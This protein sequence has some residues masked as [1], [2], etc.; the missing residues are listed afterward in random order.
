[1]NEMTT[2]TTAKDWASD[3]EVRWCPGCGDYAVLKA[4]QRTMPD[5][6]SPREGTCRSA[7]LLSRFPLKATTASKITAR[8]AFATGSSSPIRIGRGIITGD[9]T[10]CRSVQHTC[11]SAP[12]STARYYA[13]RIYDCQGANS[14]QPDGTRRPTHRTVIGG[15]PAC[16]L[17]SGARSLRAASTLKSLPDL[18][19]AGPHRGASFVEIIRLHRSNARCDS[20]MPAIPADRQ[21]AWPARKLRST[22]ATKAAR[23]MAS[24]GDE[25]TWRAIRRCGNARRTGAWPRC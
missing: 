16:S 21:W 22:A 12:A 13:T 23:S 25:G 4:V 15:S 8:P 1:M 2:V 7:R 9:A 17:G 18:L 14:R 20:S 10:S 5:L 6:G 24:G 19:K 11:T 3:Q